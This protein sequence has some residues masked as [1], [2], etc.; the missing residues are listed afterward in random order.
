MA[1]RAFSERLDQVSQQIQ[2]PVDL[3]NRIDY[4]F[5]MGSW[6]AIFNIKQSLHLVL[7]EVKRFEVYAV[8]QTY[9]HCTLF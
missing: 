3:E 4:T 5:A 8:F 9:L 2:T 6:A 1:F 7:F